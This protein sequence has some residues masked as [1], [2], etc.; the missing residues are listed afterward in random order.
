MRFYVLGLV[1]CLSKSLR[2]GIDIF[3]LSHIVNLLSFFLSPTVKFLKYNSLC[4]WPVLDCG[5]ILDN[6]ASFIYISFGI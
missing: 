5:V 4:P 3:P 1:S 6:K 2:G